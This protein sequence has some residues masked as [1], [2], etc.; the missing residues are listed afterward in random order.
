MSHTTD[1]TKVRS[2]SEATADLSDPETEEF[3][4]RVVVD[5]KIEDVNA[6]YEHAV[7]RI[8]KA[9]ERASARIVDECYWLDVVVIA[10][11]VDGSI[12][13]QLPSQL[14]GYHVNMYVEDGRLVITNISTGSPHSG[15]VGALI[16][17]VR[18][19]N[20]VGRNRFDILSD[21]NSNFAENASGAPDCI[22]TVPA[23]Y[24]PV[25]AER[26]NVGK[27]LFVHYFCCSLMLFLNYCH[28]SVVVELEVSNRSITQM[29]MNYL[30]Y[31][32]D[33][34]LVGVIG[35]K[36]FGP[37]ESLYNVVTNFRRWP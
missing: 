16:Q 8:I 24:A 36:L 1:T 19:W 32:E 26:R 21:A 13:E 12:L 37:G 30:K 10:E 7:K 22:L 31:F 29:R 5:G 28:T 23:K 34:S 17:Q 15:G 3:I 35:I 20:S 33:P 18:N 14:Y 2:E 6:R 11:G 25:G 4:V 9:T 27:I